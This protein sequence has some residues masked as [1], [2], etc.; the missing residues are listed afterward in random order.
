MIYYR[1]YFNR[2]SRNRIFCLDEWWQPN[3]HNSFRILKALCNNLFSKGVIHTNPC[4]ETVLT[5]FLFVVSLNVLVCP[6]YLREFVILSSLYLGDILE[7]NIYFKKFNLTHFIN[8]IVSWRENDR[9]F[10]VTIH[11]QFKT[12]QWRKGNN[13]SKF[14]KKD[15]WNHGQDK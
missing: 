10:E 6:H 5:T 12:T 2:N 11:S 8:G 7:K 1:I 13:Q 4:S 3:G 14:L 15:W 9:L